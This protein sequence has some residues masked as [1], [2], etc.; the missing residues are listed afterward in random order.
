MHSCLRYSRLSM[1][2][3]GAALAL[4][5]MVVCAGCA[6]APIRKAGLLNLE[7]AK[8]VQRVQLTVESAYAAGEIPKAT[9]D[10]FQRAFLKSA[11]TGLALNQALRESNEQAALTQVAA[12][13]GALDTLLDTEVVKLPEPTRGR[14]ALALEALRTV[15]ITL[16]ATLGGA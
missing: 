1:A 15:L 16:T 3:I 13:V 10:G 11:N 7:L 2:V 4:S 9:A 6:S 14:V 8:G 12:F 5:L